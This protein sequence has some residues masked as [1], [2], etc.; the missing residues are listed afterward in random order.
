[1]KNNLFLNQQQTLNFLFK[2]FDNKKNNSI[3]FMRIFSMLCIV[4][5]HFTDHGRIILDHNLHFGLNWIIMAI[6]R[7]GGGLGNCVFVLI[8]GYLLIVKAFSFRRVIFLWLEVLFYSI[9]TALFLYLIG[10]KTPTNSQIFFPIINN[11]YWFVSSYIILLFISPIL[12]KLIKISNRRYVILYILLITVVWSI[13]PTYFHQNWMRGIN[14]IEIFILLYCIGGLIRLYP[15]QNKCIVKIKIFS[16]ISVISII[17][18]EII[19]KTSGV[20]LPVDFYAFSIEKTPIIISSILIFITFLHISF[21]LSKFWHSVSQ[22]VFSVYLIHMGHAGYFIYFDLFNNEKIINS[23]LFTPWLIVS[24]LTIFFS[25]IIIDKIRILII[26]KTII[27]N[28]KDSL[29]RAIIK[30]DERFIDVN[31]K[32]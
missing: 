21:H 9:L 31:Y 4:L 24:W 28:L 19:I 15:I 10:Y 1:M 14:N 2:P 13:L 30:L 32:N 7:I 11:T 17:L 6:A 25:C 26:S 29:N 20:Q 18:S 3:E 23:I 5:F 12:N 27:Q 22:S 16:V 8:T